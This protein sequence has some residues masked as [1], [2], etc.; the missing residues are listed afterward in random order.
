MYENLTVRETLE[1]AARL[2]LPSSMPWAEK[3]E[4]VDKILDELGLR[5]CEYSKVG[6]VFE[7]GISGG[8]RKRLSIGVELVTGPR[9]LFLDE[10]V[11]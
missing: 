8:E 4:R 6:G 5:K 1:Y 2:R 3:E 11:F 10:P 9:L 7:R